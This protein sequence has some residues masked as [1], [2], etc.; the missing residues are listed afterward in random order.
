[1]T[2][3]PTMSPTLDSAA[4]AS[5]GIAAPETYLLDPTHTLPGFSVNH[6]GMSTVRGLFEGAS[7]KVVADFT[8]EGF[9][10]VSHVD[11]SNST[12]DAETARCVSASLSSLRIQMQEGDAASDFEFPFVFAPQN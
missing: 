6:L 2:T 12:A 11:T 7:G 1:M 3:S 10:G 9:G 4:A 5:A 8:V